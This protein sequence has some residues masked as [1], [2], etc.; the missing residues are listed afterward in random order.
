ME[1]ALRIG[2]PHATV[3]SDLPRIE[4]L[5]AIDEKNRRLWCGLFALS[6]SGDVRRRM[7]MIGWLGLG[8]HADAP[9]EQDTHSGHLPNLL[10]Y[11]VGSCHR[12]GGAVN[13]LAVNSR[14]GTVYV[15]DSPRYRVLCFQPRFAF[16]SSPLVVRHG[17]AT[18]DVTGTGGL[19]PLRFS[20]AAG[21]LPAGLELDKKTGLIRGTPRDRIGSREVE[22]AVTTA[23][24]TTR[25]KLRIEVQPEEPRGARF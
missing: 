9:K 15:A 8:G 19:A 16:R 5:L 12:F 3:A 2:G 14:T 7:P 4:P 18:C 21:T 22:V 24:E 20:I 23:T 11:S 10:G 1:P 25:G 13:A 6:L 17:T